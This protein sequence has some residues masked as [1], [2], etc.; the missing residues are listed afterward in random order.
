[1]RTATHASSGIVMRLASLITA[2]ALALGAVAPSTVLAQATLAASAKVLVN[3]KNGLA[4]E[5][6]DPMSFFAV[7]APTRGQPAI[8]AEHNGATYRFASEAN[9]ARFATDPEKYAPQY[10]GF[11]AYGM[12]K[13]YAAPVVIET[14]QIVDGRLMLNYDRSVQKTFDADRAAYVVSADANWP[15]VLEKKGITPR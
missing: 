7:G 9:R 5:G 13:G 14:A 2:M 15:K 10:G 8:T 4:L 3:A 12:A 1:M 6:Y 11:C